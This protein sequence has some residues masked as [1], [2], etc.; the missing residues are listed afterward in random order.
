MIPR[1]PR[2][3]C[4]ATPPT[5][6]ASPGCARRTSPTQAGTRHPPLSPCRSADTGR[7]RVTRPSGAAFADRVVGDRASRRSAGE[8]PG[9]IVRPEVLCPVTLPLLRPLPVREPSRG[10]RRVAI[11]IPPGRHP[12]RPPP[13]LPAGAPRPRPPATRHRRARS[14]GER[15]AAPGDDVREAAGGPDGC[16]AQRA[17][18]GDRAHHGG[19]GRGVGPGR[20]WHASCH[21]GREGAAP[22]RPRA[23]RRGR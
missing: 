10:A 14:T 12:T 19:A 16:G 3:V 5:G 11:A 2:A 4:S 6:P 13:P 7:C 17:L 18:S 8:I 23:M 20:H 1:C 21:A 22:W 9:Q 15:D